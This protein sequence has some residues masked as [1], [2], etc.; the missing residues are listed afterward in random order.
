MRAGGVA[1]FAADTIY[2]LAAS[3]DDGDAIARLYALKRRP[4]AKPSAVMFFDREAALCA[5]PELGPSTR[6]ALRLLLPGM[7]TVLLDNPRRRYPLACGDDPDTLGLRVPGVPALAGVGVAVVQSSANLAGEPEARVLDEVPERLRANADLVIDGGALPG[8]AS[9]VID[10]R[11]YEHGR[12]SVVRHGAVAEEA[13]DAALHGADRFDEAVYDEQIRAEIPAYDELQDELVTACGDGA[14]RILELGTGTGETARR[15]LERNRDATL[16]GL[17]E[18]PGMLA[19]ARE[20]LPAGRAELR[21]A[22]LEDPLPDG[23]FDLVASALA[24]HHLS[25][26]AK[27]RL[28]GRIREALAPGGRFVVA[29]V[30]VPDDPADAKIELTP[31]FDRPDSLAD[32]TGWL[33]QAGLQA[34]VRFTRGDLAV[35]TARRTA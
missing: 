10:L 34:S 28:F 33:E 9:T 3:A 26:A 12:W 31:G 18:H 24:V 32:L 17:D 27:R 25:P 6:D 5:L 11:G 16:V 13:V 7:V 30:I 2:G 22:R 4:L 29:D 8:T 14:R 23:P 21:V 15:L 35:L 19:V 20:R 1:V